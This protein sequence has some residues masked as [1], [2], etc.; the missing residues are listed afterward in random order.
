MLLIDKKN[1]ICFDDKKN[2]ANFERRNSFRLNVV[3][4]K[5]TIAINLKK[6]KHFLKGKIINIGNGGI[7]IQTNKSIPISEDLS[8]KFKL[9]SPFNI[10]E[11]TGKVKWGIDKNNNLF[12]GIGFNKFKDEIST[13]QIFDFL[14]V[15][16]TNKNNIPL[17]KNKKNSDNDKI[18]TSSG[19]IPKNKNKIN[20]ERRNNN[21]REQQ[22]IINFFDRRADE[23]R[24]NNRRKDED[25]RKNKSPALKEK[26]KTERRKIEHM[27]YSSEFITDRRNW[28]SNKLDIKLQHIGNYSLD[29]QK[30]KG[31]IENM[32]GTAQIPIGITG[33]CKINGEFAKG[34]FYIPFATTEGSLVLT[35]QWG[36]QVINLAGGANVKILK[37]NVH[38]SPVFL[39]NNL[40]E[41]VEFTKWID[42]NFYKI[43]KE[44]EKTTQHG[45]LLSIEPR[46]TGNKVILIF[47]YSTGDAA[48]Q[49]MVAIS[50]DAACN[51]IAQQTGHKFYLKSN[52][53]SDKKT[54]AFNYIN[55]YGK[56]V[57]AE[58]S[59]PA[60]ICRRVLNVE[61][62]EFYN[63][64]KMNL[65]AG[66]MAGITGLNGHFANALAAIFIACGQDVAHIA[67]SHTG[68]TYSE[69]TNEN[70]LYISVFIPNL[71]VGTVG[72]GTNLDTQK[73]CL[74]ILKCK[75][76]G[77]ANK[78]AEIIAVAVLAGEL[79]IGSALAKG[80]FAQGHIKYG[81]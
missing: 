57:L 1:L 29:T 42:E 46:I 53:S 49:N 65:T 60:K 21:R 48:G 9:P 10:I 7:M 50:A 19:R 68:L 59:I 63:F 3:I 36:M 43:K 77:K 72:G 8:F 66:I 23:R 5:I 58:V 67:N 41:C 61:P 70:E 75:G 6:E 78:L 52:F 38:I 80:T 71:I 79:A 40:N 44:A 73:E 35:Y 27:D 15:T 56:S 47:N 76:N 37:N 28:L 24:K 25:R 11:G 12:Y 69:V 16:D 20:Y 55:G 22:V 51:Y 31:N 64:Y 45:K 17:L 13:A 33:P 26:R 74:E 62:I 32:I 54:S 81:R 39:F 34:D 14:I 4:L 18:N 30:I 2:K